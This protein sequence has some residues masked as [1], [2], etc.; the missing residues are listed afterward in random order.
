MIERGVIE[1]ML[2]WSKKHNN[3]ENMRE[4]FSNIRQQCSIDV[5]ILLLRERLRKPYVY[6]SFEWN[7]D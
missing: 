2:I 1:L 7:F 4:E 6:C 5:S 3:K